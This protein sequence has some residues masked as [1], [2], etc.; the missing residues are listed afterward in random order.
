MKDIVVTRIKSVDKHPNADRLSLCVVTDG[1]TDY[2]VVCGATN[3]KADDNVALA[4]IGTILPPTEKFAEGLKI[5]KSKIRGEVSEG[6]LCAEN[7]L[8]LSESSEGIMI[9]PKDIVP[10]T[11]LVDALSLNDAVF[12]I[13]I[14]PNRPDCLSV[15]GIAREV[16]AILGKTLKAPEALIEE[17]GED[18][19]SF[20]NVEINNDTECLRYSCKYIDGVK[21]SD[22][23]DWLKSRLES[24]GIRSINNVVDITNYVLLEYGQP[25]HAFNYDLLKGNKIVVRNAEN[26]E[27]ITNS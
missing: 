18:I 22:S 4:T 13:A 6:M 25:L 15:Y 3:M 5:K 16:A 26:E 20:I 17:Q 1:A 7:E 21:I 11:K 24:S 19:S 9:L 12:E 10:G 8:G 14:T 2:N 27:K 23:P